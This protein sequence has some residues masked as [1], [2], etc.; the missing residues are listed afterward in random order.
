MNITQKSIFAA[1]LFALVA[2]LSCEKKL[3][4]NQWTYIQIDDDRAKWGDWDEP[5]WLRYFGLDFQ[6]INQ[7]GFVDIV[8]GRYFCRNPGGSMESDWTS[9]DL[10]ANADGCLFVD[11]DGDEFAD[12]IAAALPDVYWFEAKD[13]QGSEWQATKIGELPP[14]G[15]NNGQGYAVADLIAGGKQEI[16]LQADKGIYVCEIP[17]NTAS[18]DWQWQMVV[19]SGSDEGIGVGDIDGDGDLDL[20]FGDITEGQVEHPT[21]LDW[22]ENPGS[23]ESEWKRH[24][25]GSTEHAIDRVEVADMN[26]DDLL[27]VIVSEERYPGEEPDAHLW[28]F[29]ATD[30][31]WKRHQVVQQYSM[32]NLDVGDVDKDG[33]MDLVTNMHKGESLAT[34]VW[35]NNGSGQF[36]R[37]VVDTGK[38]MHLGAQFI[39]IDGDGDLDIVGHAWD[40]YKFLHLWRNDAVQ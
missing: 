21:I 30:D 2:A 18:G 33:D 22:A 24:N 37:H 36:T 19:T 38:E 11:V 34:Q 20:A 27:D 35:E 9:I 28:W 17:E 23:L 7:D 15:H 13:K 12:I 26:G 29:E 1:L 31:G 10:G 14:T 40:N 3:S 32:N 5:E 16:I 6:D 4:L 8:S 25:I 39:D